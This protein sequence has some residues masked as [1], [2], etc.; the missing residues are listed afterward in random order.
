MA[1]LYL[2]WP[3]NGGQRTH[4]VLFLRA[5]VPCEGTN[6]MVA[7]HMVRRLNC[8]KGVAAVSYAEKRQSSCCFPVPSSAAQ[9][10]LPGGYSRN[11]PAS[12]E[13]FLVPHPRETQPPAWVYNETMSR[14]FPRGLPPPSPVRRS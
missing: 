9:L 6:E 11:V 3:A 5:F 8:N 2:D 1:L 12:G 10:P 4:D 14:S 13:F 7:G